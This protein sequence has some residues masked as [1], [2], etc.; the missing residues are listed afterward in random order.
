[1]GINFTKSNGQ[2]HQSGVLNEGADFNKLFSLEPD[3]LVLNFRST[4]RLNSTAIRHW[5]DAVRAYP[6][7]KIELH[8]CSREVID[9][10][11]LIPG[12]LAGGRVK[13][14]SFFVDFY[15]DADETDKRVMI[16]AGK[17]YEYGKGVFKLP[18]VRC[19][20]C[21]GLIGMEDFPEKYFNFLK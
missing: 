9:Q 6:N 20:E 21:A 14:V 16:I 1:M 17:H 7:L 8:E 10:C 13:I 11:N 3:T 19:D 12:F 15:C 18:N 4:W 2:Y 5:C